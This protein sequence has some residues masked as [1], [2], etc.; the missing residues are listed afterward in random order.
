MTDLECV[1]FGHSIAR[2]QVQRGVCCAIVAKLA[3]KCGYP[4]KQWDDPNNITP[5]GF[6]GNNAR[7][8]LDI[9]YYTSVADGD[10]NRERI[11]ILDTYSWLQMAEA[12]RGGFQTI[13]AISGS[14]NYRYRSVDVVPQLE[15]DITVIY[16]LPR[17][18][19]VVLDSL[20][21]NI[22]MKSKLTFQNQTAGGTTGNAQYESTGVASNPLVGYN[23]R[24][25][26]WS[27]GF[28]RKFKMYNGDDVDEAKFTFLPSVTTGLI[29]KAGGDTYTESAYFCKPP[30]PNE[31]FAKGKKE[32]VGPGV[33]KEDVLYFKSRIGYMQ[34]L[35]R[36]PD[37]WRTTA[38]SPGKV[39]NFG[40][41]SMFA[42]EK[43]VDSGTEIYIS[44]GYQVEQTYSV[45]I[46]EKKTMTRNNVVVN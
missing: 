40:A 35:Q 42:L 7:L 1:Y 34:L 28:Q 15:D 37:L 12:L 26:K 18:G 45:A 6:A 8:Y 41:S 29:H 43:V 39:E 9:I 32:L 20:V 38:V 19:H 23:Y 4:I 17:M 24:N 31:F 36:Y 3:E 33:V 10:T 2:L 13:A 22:K 27:A 44:V 30:P 16:E 5:L 14:E 46:Y 11:E 25:K 21:L